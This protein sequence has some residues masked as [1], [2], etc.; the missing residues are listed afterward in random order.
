MS[1]A[2]DHNPPVAQS[3]NA[4]AQADGQSDP[5]LHDS[6]SDTLC[7]EPQEA[8]GR[9]LALQEPEH[10]QRLWDRIQQ[11]TRL[12]GLQSPS[13][14]FPIVLG[15]EAAALNFS[16]QLLRLGFYVPAIRPPT[17]PK[18]TSRH[19]N[20]P[21]PFFLYFFGWKIVATSKA[22]P[23]EADQEIPQGDFAQ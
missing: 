7:S 13:P 4:Y 15:S 12:T 6:I 18:G 21:F 22:C 23:S 8:K 9:S 19:V 5:R 3:G 2:S 11:F 14:V 17:V 16:Q 20:L 10:R 1:L